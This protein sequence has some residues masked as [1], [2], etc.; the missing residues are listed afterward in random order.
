MN[1]QTIMVSATLPDSIQQLSAFYLNKNYL[2]LAVGMV[3]SASEDIQ[4]KFHLVSSFKKRKLLL[5][6]LRQGLFYNNN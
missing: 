3:S 5:K 4:Q 2:F 1:R 6:V